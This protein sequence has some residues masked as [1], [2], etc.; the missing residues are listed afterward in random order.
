[1]S[2]TTTADEKI[3]DAK[4]HIKQASQA[5][6]EVVVNECW[7]HD[8]F[9]PEYKEMYREVMNDLIR[10]KNRMENGTLG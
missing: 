6:A 8:E 3:S 5:L 10:L 7:G 2:V 9:K 1:M 4:H